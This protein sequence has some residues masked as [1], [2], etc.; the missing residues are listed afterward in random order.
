MAFMIEVEGGYEG[1]DGSVY[2]YAIWDRTMLNF[3]GIDYADIHASTLEEAFKEAY[4]MIFDDF[5]GKVEIGLPSHDKIS[6]DAR[7]VV[8][9]RGSIEQ[10]GDC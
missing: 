3:T 7:D 2:R 4:R 5:A 6:I 8:I 1:D 10:R 9:D